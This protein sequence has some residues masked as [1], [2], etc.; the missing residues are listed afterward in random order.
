MDEDLMKDVET[1]I[2]LN[3]DMRLL[4]THFFR[5]AFADQKLS[6]AQYSLL[7]VLGHN[8]ESSMGQLAD[9]LGITLGAVTSLVDRL[10]HLGHVERE[11][12]KEDRRVVKV[13]L[14][15]AGCRTLQAIVDKGRQVVIDMLSDVSPEDRRTYLR[16]Q[17]TLVEKFD[18]AIKRMEGERADGR[19]LAD[20]PPVSRNTR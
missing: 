6:L 12:S 7:A 10:I 5:E 16:V 19:T 11:R 15:P 13:R 8:G 4:Q 2:R 18:L 1:G 14:T 3:R 9:P 17:K 20:A